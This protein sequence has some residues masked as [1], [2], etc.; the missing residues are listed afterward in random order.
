MNA[1]YDLLVPELKLPEYAGLD[2]AAALAHLQAK[3]ESVPWGISWK[4]LGTWCAA[5][6]VR[7]K[8]ESH[9]NDNASP[10]QSVCLTIRDNIRGLSEMLDMTDPRIVAPGGML[11]GLVAGGIIT[12]DQRAELV[13][14]GTLTR[15]LPW[16]VGVSLGHIASARQLIA[17]GA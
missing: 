14:M 16:A 17:E 12:A 6:G 13:T 15:P 2:D 1:P 4:D 10:L 5:N 11:D 8:I 9:A 3:T 7:A